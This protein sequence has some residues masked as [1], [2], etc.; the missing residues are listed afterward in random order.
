[1]QKLI[2]DALFVKT[3]FTSL[4]KTKKPYQPHP[5]YSGLYASSMTDTTLAYFE[6]R[7]YKEAI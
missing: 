3:S 1:V 2:G 4:A 7:M 6:V 5:F